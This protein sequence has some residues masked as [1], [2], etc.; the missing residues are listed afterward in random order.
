MEGTLSSV[1]LQTDG[2]PLLIYVVGWCELGINGRPCHTQFK[3]AALSPFDVILS[4]SWLRENHGVLDYDDNS[5]WQKDMEG[6]LRPLTFDLPGNVTPVF[7]AMLG[8]S[9]VRRLQLRHRSATFSTQG[10][11]QAVLDFSK[12]LPEDSELDLDDIPG[13]T[14]SERSSFS[15]VEDDVREH[16][17]HLPTVQVDAIVQQLRVFEVDVFE[18]RTQPRPPQARPGF[19][20]PIIE[21]P[22]SEPPA[23]RPY[24]VAPHHQPELDRQ[25]KALFDPG[26]IRHSSSSYSAQVLFTPKKD[27]KLRMVVN[28]SMLSVVSQHLRRAT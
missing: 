6:N 7:E 26:I 28:Y 25:V 9:R 1:S 24:P 4:E 23:R 3:S 22:D 10:Y 5:L 2:Q 14:P 12:E 21:R 11:L 8:S 13:I 16:L 18:T 27:G 15:F 20:V 17:S 19:D